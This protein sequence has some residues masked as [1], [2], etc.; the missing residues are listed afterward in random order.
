MKT[1]VRN[2]VTREGERTTWM[3]SIAQDEMVFTRDCSPEFGQ[4]VHDVLTLVQL[5]Y[6]LQLDAWKEATEGQTEARSWSVMADAALWT[7]AGFVLTPPALAPTPDQLNKRRMLMMSDKDMPKFSLS[8]MRSAKGDPPS[9]H[10]LGP[11]GI[12][13]VD[14]GDY[15]YPKFF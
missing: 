10:D 9:V 4:M 12:K 13:E 8:R 15:F 5:N 3:H 1:V 2:Y 14:A 11:L 7:P 6:V